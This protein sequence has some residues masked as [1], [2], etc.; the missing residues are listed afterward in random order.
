MEVQYITVERR[1]AHFLQIASPTSN[2]AD[3]PNPGLWLAR[4]FLKTSRLQRWVSALLFLSPSSH[5]EMVTQRIFCEAPRTY[6]FLARALSV[7]NR[8]CCDLKREWK[9]IG[10]RAMASITTGMVLW[11]PKSTERAEG[12]P[13]MLQRKEGSHSDFQTLPSRAQ[14]LLCG[15]KEAS[16]DFRELSVVYSNRPFV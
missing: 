14:R 2:L 5:K 13:L 12:A 3:Q 16:L 7:K 4:D 8:Q 1:K 9:A 10:G 11:R 15:V 6:P